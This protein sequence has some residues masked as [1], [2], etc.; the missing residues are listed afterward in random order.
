MRKPIKFKTSYANDVT[1]KGQLAAP[2]QL[3]GDC[4]RYA[5]APVHSRF[6]AIQWFVWDAETNCPDT[7]LPEVI[8]IEPT[9]SQAL[10]GLVN[11]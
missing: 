5:V 7:G 2:K 9:L 11:V 8:R 4:S 10:Q 1:R 6:D 3:F